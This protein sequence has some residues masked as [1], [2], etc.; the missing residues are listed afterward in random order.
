MRYI[1]NV[2]HRNLFGR[3][4]P[5]L[6]LTVGLLVVMSLL[7]TPSY[8]LSSNGKI[9]T[10]VGTNDP[11]TLQ[12]TPQDDVICGLGGGDVIEGLEGNDFVD[13]GQG[14]DQIVLGDGTDS[15]YGGDGADLIVGGVGND[16]IH[17]GS[18]TDTIQL[19]D[20]SD[21][22]WGD[23][24]AD[25]ITGGLG[26]DR[27][28]GGLSNDVIDG[29]GGLD[30]CIPEVQAS[31]VL[32]EISLNFTLDNAV[33]LDG[34]VVSPSGVGVNAVS[35]RLDSAFEGVVDDDGSF[36]AAIPSGSYGVF[37]S[38]SSATR[39]VGVPSQF[40]MGATSRAKFTSDGSLRIQ[41]PSAIRVSVA[42]KDASGAP[43]VGAR[44]QIYFSGGVGQAAGT[45]KINSNS[46]SFGVGWVQDEA[47]T[48]DVGVSDLYVYAGEAYDVVVTYVDPRTHRSVTK[49]WTTKKLTKNT[50]QASPK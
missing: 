33:L 50:Q 12:G 44:T 10:I 6:A 26:N 40:E 3:L 31:S 15:A 4:G 23:A 5:R 8:A 37:V 1:S 30:A 9:C 29:E 20:G 36:A 42:V 46:M 34:D 19:G 48:N 13:G 27:I 35:V 22:A 28:D 47:T 45:G 17:G 32:C 41:L 16:S 2:C 11:E 21:K 25:T 14:D 39:V 49:K 18:G 43:V 38:R 7:S 24:D